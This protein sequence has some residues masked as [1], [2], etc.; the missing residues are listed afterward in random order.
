[1][2]FYGDIL[3]KNT[4][5][6]GFDMSFSNVFYMDVEKINIA[7]E[8]VLDALRRCEYP[9]GRG[10]YGLVYAI[11]GEAEYRFSTGKRC[12]LRAGDILLLSANAAYSIVTKGE[13]RHYTV[14]FD[15]HEESSDVGFFKEPYYLLTV[16]NPEQYRQ[17]FKR[18]SALWTTKKTG[19]ELLSM[20]C[21]Y[22]LLSLIYFDIYEKHFGTTAHLRLQTAREF[23]E[24]NYRETVR[25]EELAELSD[26][27]VTNFRREWTRI[28]GESPMQYRDRIRVSYARE[29]LLS[30]YYSV[31]EVA[32]RCGFSD[33]S[34]FARFFKKHTGVSPGAFK[35]SLAVF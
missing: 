1:M 34:Y 27:S 23:I 22:E 26:M 18:L 29:Y 21:L 16:D 7:H 2:E 8:F 30:G 31:S 5:V 33:V 24:R 4:D 11:D 13:F 17:S 10:Q 32:E 35:R 20:A 19:Y 14:N 15:I 9:Y 28:Y 25:L 6:R 3:N 12:R